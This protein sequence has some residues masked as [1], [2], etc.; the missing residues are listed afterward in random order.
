MK[1]L[2]TEGTLVSVISDDCVPLGPVMPMV[3]ANT[4]QRQDGARGCC[5]GSLLLRPLG[6]LLPLSLEKLG[7]GLEWDYMSEGPS[8]G[9]VGPL[10]NGSKSG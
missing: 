7:Y 1:S 8:A 4:A 3:Q 10:R 6:S 9:P 5:V 2:I